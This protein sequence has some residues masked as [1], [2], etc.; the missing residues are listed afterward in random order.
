MTEH[1]LRQLLEALKQEKIGLEEA[2]RQL[3][4]HVIQKGFRDLGFAK[5]DTARELRQGLPEI[6]LCE[7]KSPEQIT[8]I[9]RELAAALKQP[10][11]VIATR[12]NADIYKAVQKELKEAQFHEQAGIISLGKPREKRGGKILVLTAGTSDIKVAEEAAVMAELL[13]NEVEREYDVGAAGLHR[14]IAQLDKLMAANVLIVV[15]GMDGVLPSI[16]GGLVERP[17]IAVPTS[18]GYGANFK[19]LSALLTMLNSCAP[20]IAVVNIDNGFGAG[21]LAHKINRINFPI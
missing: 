4:A 16:V 3:K 1:E 7:G 13:G 10:H 19:G 11:L 6:V 2:L 5:L 14:L 21:V 18:V 12:A 20:G 9:M 17:V 8:K 15:A